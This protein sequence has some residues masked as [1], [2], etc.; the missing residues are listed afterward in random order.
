MYQLPTLFSLRHLQLQM[1]HRK[2]SWKRQ[3][4]LKDKMAIN[5]KQWGGHTTKIIQH[6]NFQLWN[7]IMICT[8]TGPKL[9]ILL[10]PYFIPHQP[11]Q[12][13]TQ[14]TLYNTLPIQFTWPNHNPSAHR[15]SHSSTHFTYF[16]HP[17]PS[18]HYLANPLAYQWSDSTH[19]AYHSWV[20]L[21]ARY[22]VCECS[23]P[24]DSTISL[25]FLG[26]TLEC[27]SEPLCSFNCNLSKTKTIKNIDR[28]YRVQQ[29]LSFNLSHYSPQGYLFPQE[30]HNTATE[31]A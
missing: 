14:L 7:I 3:H 13:T 5:E 30:H 20:G 16:N 9:S 29:C 18:P 12:L 28:Y 27:D 6:H 11:T 4:R 15:S 17:L 21:I 19:P 10:A 24:S 22:H 25:F 31:R 23:L 1:S 2:Q 26:I 8:W